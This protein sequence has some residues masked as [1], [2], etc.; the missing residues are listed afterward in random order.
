M[1]GE[2]MNDLLERSQSRSPSIDALTAG[3]RLSQSRN[4]R[5]GLPL[6]RSSNLHNMSVGMNDRSYNGAFDGQRHHSM[7]P[8]RP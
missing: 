1:M 5:S 8:M 7:T 6:Q 4:F 3:G 2:D